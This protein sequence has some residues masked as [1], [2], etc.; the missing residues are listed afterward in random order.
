MKKKQ[1]IY[2]FDL[3][4]VIGMLM[5]FTN[6]VLWYIPYKLPD[7]GARGVE[8]FILLSGFLMSYSYYDRE[9][10]VSIKDC[11]LFALKKISPYYSLHILTLLIFV[12]VNIS[13]Y[14]LGFIKTHIL[15]LIANIFLLQNWIPLQEVYWGFNG[16]SWFLS[17]I[18]FCYFLFP[19]LLMFLRRMES[20]EKSIFLL[21]TLFFSI[22]F[23]QSI[24]K[25]G[26]YFSYRYIFHVSPIFKFIEFSFG[27][28]TGMIFIK[29]KSECDNSQN[30]KKS[31][32]ILLY[33]RGV[34]NKHF[35]FFFHLVTSNLFDYGIIHDLHSRTK[36]YH[37]CFSLSKMD[38]VS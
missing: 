38:Y 24:F 28:L 1:H 33:R 3:L 21:L 2:E 10:K 12:F 25:D 4:R 29:V 9:L 30:L 6:H 13:D 37:E 31:I 16:V 20:I 36:Q 23:L 27:A 22:L 7:F 8:L 19:C 32:T 14:G 18:M 17:S 26:N 35:S 34:Y 5:I 11:F 15:S